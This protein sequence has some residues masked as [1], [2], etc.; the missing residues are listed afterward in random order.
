MGV[1]SRAAFPVAL[2]SEDC[3]AAADR[4]SSASQEVIDLKR[5]KSTKREGYPLQKRYRWYPILSFLC[6]YL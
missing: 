2:I 3:R 6:K 5:Y 1:S 4:R